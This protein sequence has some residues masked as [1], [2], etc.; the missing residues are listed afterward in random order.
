[1]GSANTLRAFSLATAVLIGTAGCSGG[2][3]S[4]GGKASKKAASTANAVDSEGG[5]GLV[6]TEGASAAS[7]GM[8]SS[9]G[10]AAPSDGMAPGPFS[11]P[12]PDSYEQKV[13]RLIV[14]LEQEPELLAIV[15]DKYPVVY[16]TVAKVE[17][18]V[19]IRM[20][21]EENNRILRDGEE[22]KRRIA[23]EETEK[24]GR[25]LT[26]QERLEVR[27]YG[28]PLTEEERSEKFKEEL[29][30]NKKTQEEQ[31]KA[32]AEQEAAA[33][34]AREDSAAKEAAAKQRKIDDLRALGGDQYN[35]K[36]N[37]LIKEGVI[38]ADKDYRRDDDRGRN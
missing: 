24:W 7:D 23:R 20:T 6:E 17:A 18:P 32:A 28:K 12:A 2:K 11:A 33:K 1:M 14:R 8:A 26:D 15:G 19:V 9:D 4:A 27:Q 34:K 3:A 35:I 25:T 22:T 16:N 21:Y 30:A 38:D 36:R 5:D 31:A 10:M 37:E 13:A 29:E